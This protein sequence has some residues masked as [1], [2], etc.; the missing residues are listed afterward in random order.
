MMEDIVS[1]GVRTKVLLL[2]ATPVDNQLSDLR[3]QISF[4]AGNDVARNDPADA[5]FAES[6]KIRSVKDTTRHAQ[7]HFT[8]WAKKPA[9]QR[10]TRDLISAIGGDFF[11]LLDGLS[12]ARSRR[13]V[14]SYY[15]KEIS[16]LGGFPKRPPPVAIQAPIDLSERFLSFEQ[17]D[18]E[19][20]KLNLALYHPTAKLRD[21]LH[22]KFLRPT[23]TGFTAA[24]RREAASES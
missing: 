14:S 6:L 12:I 16:K 21:D 9:A 3:N 7:T 11:K 24:L 13:Q 23:K 19:I 8:I 22:Q 17:L 1:T 18:A 2:S 15:A 4:I 5:A 10:K 20:S